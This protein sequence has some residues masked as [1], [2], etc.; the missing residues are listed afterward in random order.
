MSN[1]P[2]SQI[3]I[4][5]L[6]SLLRPVTVP[7]TAPRARFINWGLS[8]ECTPL[9]VFEPESEYQCELIL[10]LARRE[11]KRVR[12]AGVGH[13]P[14]DLACTTDFM[15]RTEKLNKVIEVRHLLFFY[16]RVLFRLFALPLC[17]WAVHS[18]YT[19]GDL[20][21]VSSARDLKPCLWSLRH[22][23]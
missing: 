8:F 12:A 6:Y 11:G 9:T 13:S 19:A 7:S 3:P 23:K 22:M 4:D 10:E 21:G 15:L 14:S 18:Y 17:L 20:R 5:T 16:L 1:P 2:L